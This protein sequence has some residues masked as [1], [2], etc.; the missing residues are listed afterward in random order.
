MVL[1][2]HSACLGERPGPRWLPGPCLCAAGLLEVPGVGSLYHFLNPPHMPHVT[3][4]I[5][6]MRKLRHRAFGEAL[7]KYGVAPKYL[8][9][10]F[11]VPPSPSPVEGKPFCCG[12]SVH[13]VH[14]AVSQWPLPIAMATVAS[15]Q[16]NTLSTVPWHPPWVFSKRQRLLRAPSVHLL[17]GLLI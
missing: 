8:R 11:L 1:C 3:F 9:F 2:T 7:K 13:E 10:Q 6:Q 12:S 17:M 5:L 15:T 4:S 16:R 14:R